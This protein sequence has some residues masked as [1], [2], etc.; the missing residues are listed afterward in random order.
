MYFVGTFTDGMKNGY[1]LRV[2]QDFDAESPTTWG[3]H[4]R[5]GDTVYRQWARGDVYTVVLERWIK[6]V[7]VDDSS[8]LWG[9]WLP[10]ESLGDCYLSSGYTA[11]TVARTHG[12]DGVVR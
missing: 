4:V 9:R 10:E 6:Y 3:D 7:N 5:E 8:D 2:E 1:R 11:L 12:W